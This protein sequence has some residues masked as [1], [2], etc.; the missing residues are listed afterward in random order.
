M[1]TLFYL[2]T[3]IFIFNELKWIYRPIETT[4]NIKLFMELSKKNKGRNW[5]TFDKE[6]KD[7]LKS[8]VWLVVLF[9]WLFVGLLTFQWDAFLMML[10]LNFVVI[11]PISALVKYNYLYTLLHWSNSIV[12]LAFGVFVLI[13]KYHLHISL[14]DVFRKYF[15]I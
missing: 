8:K 11:A 3:I 12:G 15:N 9:V 4:E 14:C 2:T 10:V 1:E 7:K 6:Y 13:N 5:D